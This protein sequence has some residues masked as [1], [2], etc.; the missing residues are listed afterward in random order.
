[1][2]ELINGI[3][4]EKSLIGQGAFG[5]IY[6]GENTQT[7]ELVAIKKEMA[8]TKNPQLVYEAKVYKCLEGGMGIPK[9]HLQKDVMNMNVM[10]MDLLGPSLEDM[11]NYCYR[12]FSVKTVLMLGIELLT[13]L[14]FIHH[15]NFI[16]RDIKPDNF[17][18]GL[19][20][21]ANVVYVI[22]FGLSKRYR[23]PGTK[24]HIPYHEGKSLTGTPR[25]ASISNHMGIEQSRRDDLESLGYVLIYFLRGKLPWQGI[26]AN[27]RKQKYELIMKK[28]M[29]TSL[30]ELC[31]SLP[32]QLKQYMEYC[33]GLN[34]D[35]TP[36][37]RE[38]RRLFKQALEER[39]FR[40]DGVYDWV[41]TNERFDES[42][43]PKHCLNAKG[44]I[45]DELKRPAPP[46]FREMY[47]E[48]AYR[49]KSAPTRSSP[50][51][52][53]PSRLPQT[54]PLPQ[55]QRP[56]MGMSQGIPQ[57]MPQMQRPTMSMQPGV[58]SSLNLSRTQPSLSNMS[59]R[60]TP[61]SSMQTRG[62][63]LL[64]GTQTRRTPP[65]YGNYATSAYDDARRKPAKPTF[66]PSYKWV[67]L[68]NGRSGQ[69]TREET[70]RP[71][72]VPQGGTTK[73][74]STRKN[75][76]VQSSTAEH[77]YEPL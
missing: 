39:G 58:P 59:S 13:R 73:E 20:A 38:L 4:Y 11:F 5:Q 23:T 24:E 2:G 74:D 29:E 67:P 30:D 55:M 43:L 34:F 8:N 49:V 27:A 60:V 32:V 51:A 63:T 41:N 9:V 36:N 14:E 52:V 75:R 62:Q 44:L 18:L 37:Y 65:Y 72:Y 3:Y 10:V 16:H 28:K 42:K 56:A 53:P 19:G 50:R 31:F 15:R 64:A 25:Y 33:R 12:R 47:K 77:V 26:M 48:E 69:Y 45:L 6:L 21:R 17:V 70:R 54:A 76:Y 40:N 71:Y 35:Q 46:E 68:P 66:N 57:G 22:D 61:L 7:K 1:M